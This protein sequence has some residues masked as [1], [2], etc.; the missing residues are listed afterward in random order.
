[1]GAGPGRDAQGER[2]GHARHAEEDAGRGLRARGPSRGHVDS[3][4]AATTA[5]AGRLRGPGL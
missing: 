5:A 2:S 1:M 4:A 3:A